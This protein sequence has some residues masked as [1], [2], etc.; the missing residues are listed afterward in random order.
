LWPG[1]GANSAEG[2]A[3]THATAKKK[4]MKKRKIK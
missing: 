1:G 2:D 4:K 3:G